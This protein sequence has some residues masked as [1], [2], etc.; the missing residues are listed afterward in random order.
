MPLR[1]LIVEDEPLIAMLL[2]NFV[3]DLG[4]EVVGVAA[5]ASEVPA[6]TVLSPDLALIDINLRD[7]PTGP[8]IAIELAQR[9]SV[10]VVFVTANV[11]QLPAD[12]CGAVGAISKPFASRAIAEVID[13]ATVLRARG[14]A[15][16]LP[17]A[18]IPP[19]RQSF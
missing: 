16:P 17:R 19:T 6:L 3:S 7:G 9:H 4:C 8:G 11:E 15:P 2:E 10:T 14:S 1:V 12:F 18:M 5:S 13:F